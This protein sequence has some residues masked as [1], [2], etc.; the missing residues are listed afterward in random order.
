MTVASLPAGHGSPAFPL[1]VFTPI[2]AG[3]YSLPGS[4]DSQNQEREHVLTEARRS[5]EKAET[6]ERSGQAGS[7]QPR[8]LSCGRRHL[9][10][11]QVLPRFLSGMPRATDRAVAVAT[12]ASWMGKLPAK[13]NGLQTLSHF[14]HPVL[15]YC[16]SFTRM[17]CRSQPNPTVGDQKT[18]CRRGE[19]ILPRATDSWC[20][21][22][23]LT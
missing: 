2:P 6:E 15:G 3:N 18:T 13:S 19:G 10:K 1:W 21:I 4:R 16:D 5:H 12:E 14:Q 8:P 23:I 9:R 17:T 11:G 7:A 20:K 22:Q